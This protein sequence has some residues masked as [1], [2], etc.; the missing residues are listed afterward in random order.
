MKYL[1]IQLSDGI[2][3]DSRKEVKQ[4]T[5]EVL[6]RWKKVVDDF[7]NINSLFQLFISEVADFN[8]YME[9]CSNKKIEDLNADEWFYTTLNKHVINITSNGRLFYEHL[10]LIIEKQYADF[11]DA[12]KGVARQ[13]NGARDSNGQLTQTYFD[14]AKAIALGPVRPIPET[15]RNKPDINSQSGA[16]FIKPALTTINAPKH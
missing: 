9:I 3:I 11:E 5:L 4:E 7:D 10:S 1:G 13:V 8:K 2:G 12:M 15:T 16:W 14:M 6:E